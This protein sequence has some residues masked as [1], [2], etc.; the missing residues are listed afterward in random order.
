MPDNFGSFLTFIGSAGFIGFILSVLAENASWFGKLSS[1]Q[2]IALLLVVSLI[3]GFVSHF[4]VK[5]IPAGVVQELDEY[6]QV[7]LN[8]VVIFLA[9]KA[10]HAIAGKDKPVG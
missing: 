3:C 9:S 10:Y 7:A 8:T 5:Y 6:Y 1:G 2:K 4:A